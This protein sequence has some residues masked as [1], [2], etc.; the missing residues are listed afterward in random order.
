MERICIF[1]DGSNFYFQLKELKSSVKIDYHQF[2]Q[3]L[4]GE[5]RQL[6]RTYYY[7]CPPTQDQKNSFH[8][9][10][11][12]FSYLKNTPY[13]QLQ[14]GSLDVH[15]TTQVEKG[16][17]VRLAVDMVSLAFAHVYD[18]AILVSSD[19]DLVPAVEQ[20]KNLGK[21]VEYAYISKLSVGLVECCDRVIQIDN[22]LLKNSRA[23]Q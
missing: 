8:D 21:H 22:K 6:V 11:K 12:F 17:D 9:Q 15:G 2:S 16:V 10:Q 13:L 20:V 14:F 5:E 1:I 3:A 7:I 18:T 23:S 4:T 19:A